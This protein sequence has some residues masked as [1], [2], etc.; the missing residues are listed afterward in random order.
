MAWW[1]VEDP[2]E[3][4]RKL[5][6]PDGSPTRIDVVTPRDGA[7]SIATV[8]ARLTP[9]DQAAPAL[10]ALP[11][12]AN[13]SD[14]MR[15]WRAA[16][17][18]TLSVP[19]A[20]RMN[21]LAEAMPTAACAV[22][23]DA[24]SLWT[25][26]ALLAAFD[27]ALQRVYLTEAGEPLPPSQE[28][29][30]EADAPALRVRA[31]L[32]PYQIRG[33]AWL[34]HLAEHRRGGLLADDMGLG[35]TLQA[36]TLLAGRSGALPHL[37]VCPTSVVGN[38][39]RE[40][41]RFAPDLPVVRHHG[42]QRADVAD[43]PA[44]A[45]VVT[46]YPVMLRDASM[47]ETANWDVVVLDEAQQIKNHA[48]QTAKS[49]RRLPARMRLALTG[50]PVENRLA[51]LW[52]IMDFANPGLL[53]SRSRFA[54]RFA[55]PIESRGDARVAQRLREVVQPYLL[56]RLKADVA[57]DLPAKQES[58]LAC[59][60]TSEQARLYK[61]AVERSEEDGFGAG[62][63]RHGRI[64]KLLTELKQICNHP[65]QYLR[66]SG[67][68]RGRSGKLARAVEMLAEAVSEGHQSLV[69]T[70][71]RVMGE[72]L[73]KHLSAELDLEGVPFLHGG[74]RQ[75]AR[76]AMV[77]EFQGGANPPPILIVSLRAGGTGLNLTA[78]T[79]VLHYDRWWNPAVEDQATDRAHR[80]GQTR[81]VDVYKLVTGGTLEERIAQILER[82]RT[83]AE[84]IVGAGEDWITNL[85][86]SRLRE[87]ISLSETEVT[88]E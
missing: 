74:V 59:T 60:M 17:T 63:E 79:H 58:T 36:I 20:D 14:S 65:A 86:D 47:L 45:V 31:D 75:P 78:A 12:G 32:R 87:L 83:L 13:L 28:V 53:G 88:D 70:Q 69:F 26:R 77:E 67:P 46:S 76:D 1:G 72:L 23:R 7:L 22:P 2:A 54:K 9:V 24:D 41:A 15:A 21:A 5:G 6:L 10:A 51:E 48:S 66:Q 61:Q 30:A 35:K 33:A 38:W 25:P 55:E 68:L 52:S 56:R 37:V 8:P 81:P 62:I 64:L 80:I 27:D 71:Y 40:L 11:P 39:A 4:A 29:A 44:G 42:P 19:D 49:A 82:K 85:D 18:L 34:R 73:A 16:A 3:A 84:S 50:T 43:F 57:S